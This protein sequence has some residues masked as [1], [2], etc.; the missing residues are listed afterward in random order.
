MSKRTII[1]IDPGASGGI[2][3]KL[4][5][6]EKTASMAMPDTEGD[7]LETLCAIQEGSTDP[8]NAVAYIEQVGGFI[9]KPQP[10]SRMFTF[11]RHFGYVLGVLQALNVRIELVRPQA[12]QKELSL[13]VSN[14]NKTEWKNKLK[15][16]AQQLYPD[17]KVTLSTADALLLLEY[18]KRRGV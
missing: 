2:A 1:A 6:A 12:W 4:D 10:G 9:G 15:Q 3:Y 7:I 14:G 13:G 18:A 17:Q 11:G 8:K 5:N 16:K